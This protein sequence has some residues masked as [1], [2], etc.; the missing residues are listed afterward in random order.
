MESNRALARLTG[1]E[2]NMAL[3]GGTIKVIEISKKSNLLA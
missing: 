2:E 1:Y 3:N